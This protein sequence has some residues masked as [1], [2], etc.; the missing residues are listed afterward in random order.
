MRHREETQKDERTAATTHVWWTPKKVPASFSQCCGS[1]LLELTAWMILPCIEGLWG[2]AALCMFYARVSHINPILRVRTL[3]PS[4][5]NCMLEL[6]HLVNGEAKVWMQTRHQNLS[7]S[8]YVCWKP[9][10]TAAAHRE[11]TAWPPSWRCVCACHVPRVPEDLSLPGSADPGWEE[12]A[13]FTWQPHQGV[14]CQEG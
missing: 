3:R 7:S 12:G 14:W 5:H 9:A 11:G 4:E 6:I 1:W 10:V 13:A 2:A 8:H